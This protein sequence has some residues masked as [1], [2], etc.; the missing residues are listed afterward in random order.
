[1]CYTK[2]WYLVTVTVYNSAK[3]HYKVLSFYVFF[4]LLNILK[5][6]MKKLIAKNIYISFLR[7][8]I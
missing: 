4:L 6:I 8:D 1:M 3:L 7:T 2:T 5:R